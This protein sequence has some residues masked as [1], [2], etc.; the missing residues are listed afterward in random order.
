MQY[1]QDESIIL[2]NIISLTA[3]FLRFLYRYVINKLDYFTFIEIVKNL[4]FNICKMYCIIQ[5]R[6]N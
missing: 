4:R 3:L 1:N 5:K 2:N 6:I